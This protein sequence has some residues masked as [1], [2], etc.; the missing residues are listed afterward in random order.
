MGTLAS[1]VPK[2]LIEIDGKPLLE[3]AIDS[4]KAIGVAEIVIV[5]GHLGDKILDFVQ[6]R[7]FGVK[8]DFAFQTEQLGLAHAI[9]VARNKISDDFVLLC[10]DNMFTDSEDLQEAKRA[11]QMHQPSFLM[12]ATVT[13]THQRDRA[14]YFSGALK[15]LAPQLYEYRTID[16]SGRGMAM[17]S[18][19]CTFFAR[20]S[21]E[22]LPFFENYI[23]TET[24]F[25]WYINTLAEQDRSLLYLLRGTRY[26]LSAPEDVNTVST[27]KCELQESAGMGV[28]A[29][30][31]NPKGEVLLQHR[32]DNPSI[33][34]PGH[35]AL[36]GGTVEDRE[37]PY[38]AVRR[39][40]REE[41]G[42]E[43]TN[44]GLFREFVQNGKCEFAFIGEVNAELDELTLTEGQGMDFVSPPKLSKLLIRPDDNETLKTY[45]GDWNARTSGV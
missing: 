39:E 42:Y 2:A 3:K 34:Y 24:K 41:I 23:G 6:G 20:R 8:I 30:L 16:E 13:P 19:G 45:F 38:D 10:P 36:F 7:D 9:Y 40:V 31:L 15:N 11:F 14:K 18:T 21:V 4:L 26:D 44:F 32:D 28:S 43:L 1:E 5:T 35:W 12:V 33:R 37:S 22:L 17:T 25:E 29:I 27:L